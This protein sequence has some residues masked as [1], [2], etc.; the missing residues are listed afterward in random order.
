MDDIGADDR[1]WNVLLFPGRHRWRRLDCKIFRVGSTRNSSA[2][3]GCSGARFLIVFFA[4]LFALF[5]TSFGD[6]WWMV[7]FLWCFLLFLCIDTSSY[8]PWILI[9]AFGKYFLAVCS[10]LLV[11][12]NN[13]LLLSFL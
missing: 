10:S 7:D 4:S 11:L 13:L 9:I 12:Y 3:L 2:V 5:A 1:Y 6:L 8:G